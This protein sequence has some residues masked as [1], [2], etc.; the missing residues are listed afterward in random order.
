MTFDQFV[1]LELLM[2][3][4]ILVM[5]Y[6]PTFLICLFDDWRWQYRMWHNRSRVNSTMPPSNHPYR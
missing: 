4:A 5:A 2:I 6:V 1:L 3:P